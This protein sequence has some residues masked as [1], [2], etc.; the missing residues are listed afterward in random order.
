MLVRYYTGT[1]SEDLIFNPSSGLTSVQ[2]NSVAAASAPSGAMAQPRSSTSSADLSSSNSASGPRSSSRGPL[3][4]EIARG[5]AIP[6]SQLPPDPSNSKLF[7]SVPTQEDYARSS[8]PSRS[9]EPSPIDRQGPSA[10]GGTPDSQ[11]RAIERSGLGL[12]S[13]L[14]DS[15]PLS[16]TPPFQ[17]DASASGQ[18]ANSEM[19]HYP[20]LLQAGNGNNRKLDQQRPRDDGRKSFH[21]TSLNNS[22]APSPTST[23]A[24]PDRVPSPEKLDASSKVKISGPMNGTPIP[25][26]FK[27]GGKDASSADSSAAAIDR[28]EKAKS[29]SFWGF[30]KGECVRCCD[31]DPDSLPWVQRALLA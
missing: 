26:G 9:M 27:F 21:P 19:G 10:A 4:E 23:T 31:W 22:L 17:I 30:G 18:R 11:K 20:D 16:G 6:I 2:S 1:Y 29:R 5:P 8:S 13:S 7:Q 15:S 12:P 25:S 24:P 14:P 28:R 3:R